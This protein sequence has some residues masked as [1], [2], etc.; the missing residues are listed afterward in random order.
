MKNKDKTPMFEEMNQVANDFFDSVDDMFTYSRI[1]VKGFG[2]IKV[3]FV[4][5]EAGNLRMKPLKG[6]SLEAWR[7]DPDLLPPWILPDDCVDPE[8]W[9]KL[10]HKAFRKI[11]LEEAKLN[12]EA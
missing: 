3:I 1:D 8:E 5:D 2:P 7:K 6:S 11:T 4:R 9:N 12:E 10:F